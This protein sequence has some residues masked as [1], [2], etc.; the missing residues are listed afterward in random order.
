MYKK[1][2]L[3]VKN[4]KIYIMDSYRNQ[5]TEQLLKIKINLHAQI[6]MCNTAGYLKKYLNQ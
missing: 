2:N 6:G 5:S 4:N 3:G 1:E